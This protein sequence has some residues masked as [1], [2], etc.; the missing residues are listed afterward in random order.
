[1]WF[2]WEGLVGIEVKEPPTRR[3]PNFE[4]T[5]RDCYVINMFVIKRA[6]DLA[7]R[8]DIQLSVVTFLWPETPEWEHAVQ[9]VLDDYSAPLNIYAIDWDVFC[10][11]I[12]PSPGVFRVFD[13]DPKRVGRMG[14]KATLVSAFTDFDPI[15]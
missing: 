1:M 12:V 4:R 9:A 6:W 11:Q 3:H 13:T 7:Y 10:H 8:Y 14:G 2:V 5:A 15:S